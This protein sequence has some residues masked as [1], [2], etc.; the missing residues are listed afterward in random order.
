MVPATRLSVSDFKKHFCSRFC[1][2][3]FYTLGVSDLKIA[4]GLLLYHWGD[5][6][7]Y[8]DYQQQKNNYMNDLLVRDGCQ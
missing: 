3:W 7:Y 5:H 2:R 6:T 8:I 4:A 1:L